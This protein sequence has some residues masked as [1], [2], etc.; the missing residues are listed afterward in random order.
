MKDEAARIKFTAEQDMAETE[1]LKGDVV[2]DIENSFEKFHNEDMTD[3]LNDHSR[4]DLAMLGENNRF[5]NGNAQGL[6]HEL[7]VLRD[8]VIAQREKDVATQTR[9]ETSVV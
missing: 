2:N 8:V 5:V 3:Y 7:N 6:S 1:A 4:T 9:V